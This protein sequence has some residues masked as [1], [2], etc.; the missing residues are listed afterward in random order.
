MTSVKGL[1]ANASVTTPSRGG[2]ARKVV[3]NS[4]GLSASRGSNQDA[5][6]LILL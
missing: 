3:C 4:G 5:G 2:S 6:R 1:V